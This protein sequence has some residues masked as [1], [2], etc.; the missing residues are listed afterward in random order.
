MFRDSLSGQI[1]PPQRTTGRIVGIWTAFTL[2]NPATVSIRKC[3]TTVFGK[4]RT[5]PNGN[6]FRNFTLTLNEFC[7]KFLL[8]LVSHCPQLALS[9]RIYQ[10]ILM[11]AIDH[12]A[13]AK[14][15]KLQLPIDLPFSLG[16][17]LGEIA[18]KSALFCPRH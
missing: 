13:V 18:T 15:H 3:R 10:P 6:G 9:R 7:Y 14:H 8:Y 12:K 5:L 1:V 16:P 2:H 11:S 4:R 17:I